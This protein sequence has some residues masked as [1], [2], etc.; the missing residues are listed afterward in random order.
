MNTHYRGTTDV[1]VRQIAITI[2]GQEVNVPEGSTILTACNAAGK[3][4]PTLCYGDTLTP[5]MPA[6][7]A[8]WSSRARVSL[9]PPAPAGSNPAWRS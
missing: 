3:D 9:C 2:D 6:G 8:W 5:K 1:P 7:S 4:T